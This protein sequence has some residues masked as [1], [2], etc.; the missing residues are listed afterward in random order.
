MDRL[1]QAGMLFQTG[2][3]RRYHSD[4]KSRSDRLFDRFGA[5]DFHYALELLYTLAYWSEGGR[6]IS[7]SLSRSKN[8]LC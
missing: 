1:E 7:S 6:R 3:P 2:R 5:W 4:A 8:G